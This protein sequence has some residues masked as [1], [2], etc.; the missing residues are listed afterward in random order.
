MYGSDGIRYEKTVNGVVH[1]YYLMGST[2]TAE[3]IIDGT[4]TTYIEYFYDNYGPYGF[5]ID[6]TFY[7]YV[8]NLQGDV[9]QIRDVNNNLTA[10]YVYDA[11]GKVLSVTE[12]NNNNIG[13][14]NAIRYRG[15]Y[16]DTESNLYYL[17][18][19]YYDPQIKRFLNPDGILGANG[20]IIGYNMYAYCSNAPVLFNDFSGLRKML[21]D[22]DLGGSSARVNDNY[23]NRARDGIKKIKEGVNDLIET[24]R[25]FVS[26]TLTWIGDKI[27]VAGETGFTGSLSCGVVS[28]SLNVGIVTDTEGNIGFNLTAGISPGVYGSA[29]SASLDNYYTL[30]FVDNINTLD[31]KGAG[32]TGGASVPIPYINVIADAYAGYEAYYSGSGASFK[33]SGWGLTT[34][35]GIAT[36]PGGRV[37]FNPTVSF[38]RGFNVLEFVGLKKKN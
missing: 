18:A 32:V 13:S 21:Y 14:K 34:G 16:Y 20:D 12:S 37:S 1:K 31:G 25:D 5:S 38:V 6:G 28:V 27:N 24:G 26:D 33:Q 36:A 23:I 15:Y 30:A 17:N 7:Y 29:P 11:W 22:K 19:R 8:K 4:N 3:T 9:T 2:I 10:S 35:A